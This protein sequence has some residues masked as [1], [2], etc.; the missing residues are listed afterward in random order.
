[1]TR[2]NDYS[3]RY[4]NLQMSRTDS[5]ILTVMLHTNG[6]SHI[7][8]GKAHQ[9]FPQAMADIA[10]D[11]ENEVVILTGAGD[12]FM[13]QIDFS[14]VADNTL[15][16]NWYK[17]VTEARHMLLNLLEIPVPVIAAVN[18]P[19]HIHSEYLLVNDIIL[20]SDTAE[21]QDKVHRVGSVV[22]ADGVQI[23]WEQAL[24]LIRSRYFLLTGQVISAQ[25][26]LSLGVVHEVVP[27]AELMQRAQQLAEDLLQ[28]SPLARRYN[29]LI[30]TRKWKQLVNDR[31]PFEMAMEGHALTDVR[32]EDEYK[33]EQSSSF[34]RT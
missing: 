16:R 27:R 31:V 4:E 8:T 2:F 22:P 5:G 30:M 9:E 32:L 15:P 1:M 33:K 11:T 23:A 3:N 20:A 18:G 17:I 34:M 7:H 25:A 19:V 29:R 24:G 13:T 14:T 28:W 26:A 21:F 12:D 10:A 6:G